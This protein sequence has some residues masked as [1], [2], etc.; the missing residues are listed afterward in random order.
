MIEA[1]I[2]LV[3]VIVCLTI[4]LFFAEQRARRARAELAN[5]R[6]VNDGY[7]AMLAARGF[8]PTQPGN[9]NDLLRVLDMHRPVGVSLR[10][11][12]REL[13]RTLDMKGYP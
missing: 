11:V 8:V 3:S 5:E 13:E 9:A 4:A 7:R 12:V 10:D 2:V 1:F 6:A